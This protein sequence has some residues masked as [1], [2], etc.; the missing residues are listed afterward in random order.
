LIAVGFVAASPA[1]A[2]QCPDRPTEIAQICNKQVGAR[3]N[4][5]TGRYEISDHKIAAKNQCVMEMS[6]VKGSR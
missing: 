4:P 1:W 3:C 2:L 5:W 6:R